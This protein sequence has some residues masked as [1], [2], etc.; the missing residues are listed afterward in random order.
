MSIEERVQLVRLLAEHLGDNDITERHI[1]LDSVSKD[2]LL[3]AAEGIRSELDLSIVAGVALNGIDCRLMFLNEE[4][5]PQIDEL[6]AKGFAI[7]VRK[8]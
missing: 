1:S 5:S 6:V 8:I 2:L 4:A 7:Y 3:N